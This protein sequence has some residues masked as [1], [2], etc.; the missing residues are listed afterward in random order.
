MADRRE[1]EKQDFLARHGIA[2]AAIEALPADASPRRYFRI[3]GGAHGPCLLM[4]CPPGAEDP[5]AFCRIGAHLRRLGLS[6]PEIYEADMGNG[7]LLIED[8]G[9]QTY[10]RLLDRG[11]TAEPLYRLAVD[12][13]LHLHHAQEAT[14]IDLP[15]Y[16]AALLIDE[17]ILLTDWFLPALH[18]Q[19]CSDAAR[20]AFAAA[21]GEMTEILHGHRPT[22]VLR[23]YHVDNLML[24]SGREGLAACGILDFQSAVIGDAAYDIMSLLEDARRDVPATL[25]QNMRDY[26]LRHCPPERGADFDARFAVLAAQR[27]A[28]VL[29]IFVRLCVRD[30]K[31]GYLRHLP[32]VL[33]LFRHSLKHPATAPLAAWCERRWPDLEQTTIAAAFTTRCRQADPALFPLPAGQN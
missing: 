3:S 32:R 1:N 8:F 13:L 16:N 20:Q 11:E 7:F 17:A 15:A 25:R 29:G 28:K 10:T 31:A 26:Y 9:D 14:D 23:D 6:A 19:R 33:D 27:H 4:D 12:A 30:G 21:I 5:H 2:P 18:G 22:L 24:L